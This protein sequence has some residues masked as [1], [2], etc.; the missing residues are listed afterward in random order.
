[1][2]KSTLVSIIIVNFNTKA[3]LLA[4]IESLYSNVKTPFEIIVVDNASSDGSSAAVERLKKKNISVIKNA[5]NY[6]FA[7]ANNQGI[8]RAKGSFILLLNSDTV[9]TNDA[10]TQGISVLRAHPKVGVMS[11]K[12]TNADGS[13]QATGGYFP[14]PLRLFLWMT[15]LDDIPFI[16]SLSRSFHPPLSYY[17]KSRSLDWVTG[18]FFLF[19]AEIRDTVGY[20]DEEYFM[21][22]EEL[23]YCYRIQATGWSVLYDTSSSIIHLGRASS[24]NEFALLSEYKNLVLFYK[25]HLP[26]WVGFCRVMLKIGALARRI[27]FGILGKKTQQHIYEKAFHII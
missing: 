1:M 2:E 10:I 15:F 9:V 17:T 19:R 8:K 6:G 3:L 5:E 22:V 23:D 4:C 24:S 27:I 16:S 21:Y 12:L 14:Y 26:A 13:L 11:C 25:K 18:A 7:K 20:L